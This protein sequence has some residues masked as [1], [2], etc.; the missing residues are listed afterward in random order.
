MLIEEG[1]QPSEFTP[2][3][4][5]ADRVARYQ[6]NACMGASGRQRNSMQV[7]EVSHVVGH[8]HP[9]LPHRFLQEKMIRKISHRTRCLLEGDDT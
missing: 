8:E 5:L 7:R 3:V 9:P 1:L 2:Y 6:D 4:L